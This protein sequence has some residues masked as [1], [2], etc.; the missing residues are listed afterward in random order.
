MDSRFRGNDFSGLA[1]RAVARQPGTELK[2]TKRNVAEKRPPAAPAIPPDAELP[3]RLGIAAAVYFGLSLLYF[4]PSFLPGRQMF[5]TD[6]LAGSYYFYDFFADRFGTGSLPKWVPYVYGGMPVYANPGSA[7]HPV[8]LL[9]ETLLPTSKVLGAIFVVQFWLAGLG[10]YLLA[11]ELGCR[12]WVAFVAGIAF[13]FTG[14][15]MSWV[16]AG[17]DGRIMVATM[18]PLFFFFLQRGIRTAAVAPF[19]GAAATLAF[20]LL[21]FQIQNSYYLILA[22]FIW[23]VY[24]LFHFGLHRRPPALAKTVALGLRLGCIRVLAGVSKFPALP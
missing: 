8:H 11:R 1:A 2:A 24:L 15:T 5:G 7:F 13:Q 22:G 21:S 17:H 3:I 6:Y 12:T 4:L 14:V 20:A 10:M 18:A 9:A 19:A 16:Y 23:A